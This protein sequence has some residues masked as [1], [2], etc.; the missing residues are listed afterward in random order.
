MP[1]LCPHPHVD[2][3]GGALSLSAPVASFFASLLLEGWQAAV[4][5]QSSARALGTVLPS[6]GEVGVQS[7]WP[8]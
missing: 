5:A 8:S 6:L 1:R 7:G 4:A 3:G 2:R